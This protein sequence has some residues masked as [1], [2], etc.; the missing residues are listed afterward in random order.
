MFQAGEFVGKAVQE[1]GGANGAK[2]ST[3]AVKGPTPEATALSARESEDAAQASYSKLHQTRF[4]TPMPL[5]T[6][7]RKR[8]NFIDRS[9]SCHKM[10]CRVLQL[11]LRIILTPL[12]LLP[13]RS[14][15]IID[16]IRSAVVSHIEPPK[17]ST[18]PT[19]YPPQSRILLWWTWL[20]PD[21][22]TAATKT[23]KEGDRTKVNW[24]TAKPCLQS[25]TGAAFHGAW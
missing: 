10:L 9:T 18:Q 15:R 11:K 17:C 5:N 8:P 14:A 19:T 4:P 1:E 23:V 21:L 16:G 3:R 6:P 22:L 12:S 25:H 13:W 20:H 7:G 2:Y 24:T